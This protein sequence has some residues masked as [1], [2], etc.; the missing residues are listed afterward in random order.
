[1]GLQENP[2]KRYPQL[3]NRR[4]P[5]GWYGVAQQV[6]NRAPSTSAQ[7]SHFSFLNSNK[8]KRE[9]ISQA[10]LGTPLIPSPSATDSIKTSLVHKRNNDTIS[11]DDGLAIPPSSTSRAHK[12][13]RLSNHD[14]G[15][16]NSYGMSKLV[17]D[18]APTITPSQRTPAINNE[19]SPLLNPPVKASPASMITSC[20]S[21][22]KNEMGSLDG[23]VDDDQH[24]AASSS[25][26][27]SQTR[28]Q[29]ENAS[30]ATAEARRIDP[31]PQPT[32][33]TIAAVVQ[34]DPGPAKKDQELKQPPATLN[35]SV[36]AITLL[37]PMFID[38]LDPLQYVQ[39]VHVLENQANAAVFLA[40]AATTNP[41]ICKTWL[42]HKSL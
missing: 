32:S 2:K 17:L 30:Q 23:R 13:P 26:S 14:P 29:P 19:K 10:N 37:A 38:F 36:E 31:E 15:K 33:Q 4:D 24:M 9:S 27:P 8:D 11:S 41:I 6:F 34:T 7:N 18:S 3:R 28:P 22:R 20:V 25:S 5:I 35:P 21:E 40:L 12:H 39:F 1:V 42:L 16:I